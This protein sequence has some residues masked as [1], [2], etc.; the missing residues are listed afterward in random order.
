MRR[1]C[2]RR[3]GQVQAEERGHGPTSYQANSEAASRGSLVLLSQTRRA[4]S[5][6]LPPSLSKAV[7]A[8]AIV[9][10]MCVNRTTSGVAKHVLSPIATGWSS[11]SYTLGRLQ[12]HL[13]PPVQS[14]RISFP[15]LPFDRNATPYLFVLTWDDASCR[16]PSHCVHGTEGFCN[17]H[18][19]SSLVVY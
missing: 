4:A 17:A 18:G 7:M 12:Q 19:Q 2:R 10:P 15:S 5:P 1:K 9:F 8:C 3:S 11:L 14:A 6:F 13:P 16:W